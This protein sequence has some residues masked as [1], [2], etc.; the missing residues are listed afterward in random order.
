[1]MCVVAV[2]HGEAAV[3]VVTA[4][5]VAAGPGHGF[6]RSSGRQLT[7]AP[8]QTALTPVTVV[9]ARIWPTKAWGRQKKHRF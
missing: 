3:M 8:P 7:E 6:L 2:V 9:R 1:M 4:G 5:V